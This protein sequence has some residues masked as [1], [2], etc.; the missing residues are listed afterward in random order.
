ML[1][2]RFSFVFILLLSGVLAAAQQPMTPAEIASFK[3]KTTASMKNIQSLQCNFTQTKVLSYLDDAV[4]SSGTL[5]FQSPGK[6]RWEYRTPTRYVVVF[7]NDRMYTR[8]KAGQVMETDFSGH[9]RFSALSDVLSQVTGQGNFFDESRFTT[10]YYKISNGYRAVL[11]PREKPLG[12][13]IKQIEL[14]ID[15]TS[16]LV[17]QVNITDPSGDY[18]Q[19][20]FTDQRKN[21]PVA[22]DKFAIK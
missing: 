2:Y 9:K 21:L 6:I 8:D 13:Y 1:I 19:L 18:I 11:V 7:N 14:S 5:Y 17:K 20:D 10:S 3:E 12:R 16:F 4:R 22:D 15:A